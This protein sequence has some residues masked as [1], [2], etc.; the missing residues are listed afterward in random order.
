VTK[1]E[2]Q[3]GFQ[4]SQLRMQRATHLQRAVIARQVPACIACTWLG[5][6]R[7]GP[8]QSAAPGGALAAAASLPQHALSARSQRSDDRAGLAA[9][10]RLDVDTADTR[11]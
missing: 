8:Q 2:R 7:A 11:P 6:G 3:Q 5:C 1:V 9:I 10:H 4:L